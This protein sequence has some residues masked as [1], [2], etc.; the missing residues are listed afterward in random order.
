MTQVLHNRY[1]IRQELGQGGMGEVFLAEDTTLPGR[2]VALKVNTVADAATQRQ[3]QREALLLARLHHP[4]LPR[5][6]DYFRATDGRQF[7]VMDYIRGENLQQ[8]I[9]K[10]TSELQSLV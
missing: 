10:H 3:F 9:G 7:L 5:V 1:V 6:S 8:Q 4:N 2:L